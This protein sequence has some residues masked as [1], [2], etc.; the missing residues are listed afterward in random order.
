MYCHLLRTKARANDAEEIIQ[1]DV[2]SVSR[3][4]S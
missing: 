4:F 2:D 1:R 3:L